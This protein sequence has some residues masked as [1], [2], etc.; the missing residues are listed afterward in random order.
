[1]KINFFD[2]HTHVQFEAFEK[3]REETIKRAMEN[4][5]GMVNVGTQKT[6]SLLSVELSKKCEDK[7]IYASV[8]LHPIHTSFS[9]HDKQE[10]KINDDKAEPNFDFEY[11]KK[12]ALEKKVLAIGECGLDYFRIK[13]EK[14]EK[15]IQKEAFIEQIILAKEIKKP[16]M[17][18][19][20]NA[21]K[22]LLEILKTKKELLLD[23]P[24][25]IHFFSGDKNDA[26][27]LL[28]LGFYFTFGG[29][30]TFAKDYDHLIKNIPMNRILSET[31]APYVSPAPYR[32]KRNEPLFVIE[33]VKKIAEIKNKSLE[34]VGA[35]II[36]NS[37]SIFGIKLNLNF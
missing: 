2:A 35:E 20:R 22:D 17:I 21:F 10:L 36:K 1:M 12:L 32:K 29:V 4:G 27:E 30:I 6:T 8:G 13:N 33:V 19:C 24:G 31:D 28:E 3:D 15:R 7:P 26:K 14:E 18:H 25:I 9:Y 5:V 34:E 23:P 16:L 37:E 11:Y